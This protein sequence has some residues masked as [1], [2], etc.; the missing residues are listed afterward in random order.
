[1]QQQFILLVEID[2]RYYL[3]D[4]PYVTEPPENRL[5]HPI[6]KDGGIPKISRALQEIDGGKSIP[7]WGDIQ[8]ATQFYGDENLVTSNLRGASVV[9]KVLTK[10]G[11]KTLLT[12]NI[13]S[14]SGSTAGYLTLEIADPQQQFK[15]IKLPL[16]RYDA[17]VMSDAF[18]LAHHDKPIPLCFG[19]CRNITPT[20]IDKANLTYQ[21]HD[22]QLN[23]IDAV[24]DNGVP[25]AF[26][27]NVN[28]GS[29]NL[30]HS[31]VGMVSANVTGKHGT[32][33]DLIKYLSTHFGGINEQQLDLGQLPA[34]TIGVHISQPISLDQMLTQLMKS[35]LGWWGFTRA[36]VLRTRMFEVADPNGQIIHK[37]LQLGEVSWAD[38]DKLIGN[39]PLLYRRNWSPLEAAKSVDIDDALWL[40]SP[41]AEIN[42]SGGIGKKAL[43]QI[44][45]YF[46]D[47]QAAE[48]IGQKAIQLF[49]QPR[50]RVKL[51]VPLSEFS[52]ELGS[53]F[54]LKDTPVNG[55]YRITQLTEMWN[56][57]IPLIEIE[58][59]G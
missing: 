40:R 58:G 19:K 51:K 30:T 8:L 54:S 45:G 46:D 52:F 38:D 49:G 15:D 39:V 33:P 3:S 27:D 43:R 42:V 2:N 41:G 48:T 37:H 55:L 25:I 5:Y 50:K 11:T 56:A 9:V 21:V 36:G 18:P 14:V 44:D 34:N 23:S 17:K 47:E 10:Q 24:Y 4:A 35:L 31:P 32:L 57:A 26:E 1:M 22:G 13:E 29:F 20:L 6:I 53:S 16:N 28:E 7:A 59:W 12:G